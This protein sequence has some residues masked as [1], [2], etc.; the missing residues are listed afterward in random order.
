[1]KGRNAIL[2]IVFAYVLGI[3]SPYLAFWGF[4]ALARL[5]FPG[6]EVSRLTSPDG[7]LDA[8]VVRHNPG[9]MS[10]YLYYLYIV[11][12][13]T[14]NVERSGEHWIVNTSEGD[15]LKVRWEKPHFLTVDIGDSHVKGF[16]N[17]WYSK[18]VNDYYVELTL[19]SVSGKRYL[20]ESGRLRSQHE[21]PRQ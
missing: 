12:S 14:T 18:R 21:S 1:M 5:W 13:G 20:Q 6:E 10:S 15:E 4:G 7:V 11:P 19:S 8:V 9:A 17:L 16:A 2:L 3:A